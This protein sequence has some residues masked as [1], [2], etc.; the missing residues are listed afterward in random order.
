MLTV[1]PV[2]MVLV[3]TVIS[4]LRQPA[5][6]GGG[7]AFGLI[8]GNLVGGLA[9]TAAYLLVTLF[10]APIFL[11]LVALFVGLVFGGQIVRGAKFAPIYTVGLMTFLLVLGLGISPL[12]A[13]SGSL[14]IARVLDVMVGAAYA[15]GMASVL[16]FAFRA[17]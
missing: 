11:L 4:I 14:F 5:D 2:S 13:D 3:L 8:L 16:R 6:L 7:T 17:R 15:I 9:A 12:P 1:S 10:P